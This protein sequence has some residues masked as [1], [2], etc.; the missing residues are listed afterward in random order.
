MRR[1]LGNRAARVTDWRSE[2]IAHDFHDPGVAGLASGLLN[3]SQQVGGAPGLAI[4]ST[5]ATDRTSSVIEELGTQPSP[6]QQ[7]EAFVDGFRIAFAGGAAL[8]ALGAVLLAL[9]LQRSDVEQV[10]T[11]ADEPVTV[12]A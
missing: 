3:T 2:R 1:L 7:T 9:M 8:M 6:S 5:L 11:E 12:A 10:P 4:L